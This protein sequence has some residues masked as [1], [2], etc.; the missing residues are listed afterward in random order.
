[1][2]LAT[3]KNVCFTENNDYFFLLTF[4]DIS[5]SKPVAFEHVSGW[6]GNTNQVVPK[7]G[8]SNHPQMVENIGKIK[9]ARSSLDIEDDISAIIIPKRNAPPPP[10][11]DEPPSLPNRNTKELTSPV[12]VEETIN[13]SSANN[14]NFTNKPLPKPPG[15]LKPLPKPPQ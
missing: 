14:F 7:S 8:S 6:D 5:F 11:D 10:E 12:I 2:K 13:T 9:E 15:G 1:M 3:H 4:T